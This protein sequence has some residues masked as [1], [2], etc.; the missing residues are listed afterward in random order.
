[1]SDFVISKQK[2]SRPE[3]I[4]LTFKVK[5]GKKLLDN[6]KLILLT[7]FIGLAIFMSVSHNNLMLSE[8]LIVSGII[9]LV[10]VSHHLSKRK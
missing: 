2:E 3:S 5:I 1:M 9:L 7:A 4:T 6:L 10:F 8:L